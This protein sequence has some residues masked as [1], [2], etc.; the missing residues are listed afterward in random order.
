MLVLSRAV[1]SELCGFKLLHLS[2]CV[3]CVPKVLEQ[4]KYSLQKEVELRTR[5]VESLQSDYDY[6]KSQQRRQLQ[7][8]QEHL[9]QSHSTALKELSNKVQQHIICFHLV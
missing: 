3:M 2:V 7:E 5:M 6:V 8:Q 4:D 1:H 9:E